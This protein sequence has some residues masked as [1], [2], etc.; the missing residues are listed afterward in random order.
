MKQHISKCKPFHTRRRDSKGEP[1]VSR[2]VKEVDTN[3]LN[4]TH[5]LENKT[6]N[7]RAKI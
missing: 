2:I 4:D 3:L 5:N 6:V 7:G 1:F